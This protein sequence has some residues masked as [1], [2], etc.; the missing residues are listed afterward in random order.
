MSSNVGQGQWLI[1]CKIVSRSRAA[2]AASALWF[3]EEF[4]MFLIIILKKDLD[5]TC[6]SYQ[7]TSTCIAIWTN[8]NNSELPTV[9][10]TINLS[11]ILGINCQTNI[12][13]SNQFAR[14]FIKIN[15]TNKTQVSLAGKKVEFTNESSSSSMGL[16][17]L[18][19]YK[20]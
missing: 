18:C 8:Q 20:E 6:W 16:F 9:N 12:K 7:Q 3:A 5:R 11:N 19:T 4:K 10:I 2:C 14:F 15:E 1:E 17:F 13:K